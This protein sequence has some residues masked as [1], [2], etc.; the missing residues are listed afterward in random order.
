MKEFAR[1]ANG[2]DPS[3]VNAFL[4]Q[5]IDQIEKIVGELKAKD[6]KIKELE[7]KG[8]DVDKIREKLEQYQ[9]MENTL[10]NAI[11]MAQKTSDQN[12][13]NAYRESE[14]IVDEAKKNAN[15]IVNEALL[16][17]EKIEME[18]AMLK[19]NVTLFKRRLR[20]LI[21]QQLEM[22]DDIEKV[23]F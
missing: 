18:S 14:L 23:D 3:E 20:G 8:T 7:E 2:Y 5:V 1:T 9:R 11:L 4:D 15:R 22:V 17:A 16:R 12:K 21:E 10:N 19:R 6:A 13:A